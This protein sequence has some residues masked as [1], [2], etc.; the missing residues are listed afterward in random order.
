[1]TSFLR[2]G[3]LVLA[4]GLV[5]AAAN[6]AH[7][8]VLNYRYYQPVPTRVYSYYPTTVAYPTTATYMATPAF[9]PPV[10]TA[11][12]V[13]TNYPAVTT[14]Y[15]PPVTYAQPATVVVP[16]RYVFRPAVQ[17]YVPAGP[18]VYMPVGPTY[19]PVQ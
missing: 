8:Q 2:T 13:V 5:A 6:S 7:A 17:M 18:S 14:Y 3:A 16:R 15:A 1:M 10:A 4:M 19:V 9:A 12:P 11:A